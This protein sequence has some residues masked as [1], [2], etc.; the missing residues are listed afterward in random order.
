MLGTLCEEIQA[1]LQSYTGGGDT[2][3]FQYSII[4][5]LNACSILIGILIFSAS[6]GRGT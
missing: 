4:D 3:I 2:R 1:A 6:I 5:T